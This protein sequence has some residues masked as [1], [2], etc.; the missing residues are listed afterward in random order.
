MGLIF[1]CLI[2]TLNDK[3]K[4]AH[5]LPASLKDVLRKEVILMS[6]KENLNI[7]DYS[8]L[9]IEGI[10][11]SIPTVGPALQTAYFGRKS[12]KRFKRIENFYNDLS[13]HVQEL[14]DQM[15]AKTE[16][17]KYSDQ[18]AEFMEKSNDLVESDVQGFKSALLRNA[19]LTIL[20]SPSEV[21]WNEEQYFTSTIGQMDTTDFQVLGAARNGGWVQVKSVIDFF[22]G[23]LDRFYLKG[24]CERLTSLGYFEKRYGNINMQGEGTII[25]TYYR[26]SN[27]GQNL[28]SFTMKPPIKKETNGNNTKP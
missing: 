14:Q 16:I 11:A 4:K 12:E 13:Q 21:N 8:W 7:K 24:L 19:F 6:E 3:I 20:K 22:N 25:D 2:K 18:I 23:K 10:V 15:V 1:V 5:P 9:A 27:L 17:E 28:L 26:I